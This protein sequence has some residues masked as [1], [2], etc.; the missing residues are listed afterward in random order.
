MILSSKAQLN[1]LDK[2]KLY[3][4]ASPYT[5]KG[6]TGHAKRKLEHDRYL[7][8]TH[9][10][11]TLMADYGLLLLTP[12]TASYGIVMHDPTS[13]LGG[14]WEQWAELD[15]KQITQSDGG[16]IVAMMDGWKESTGVT[17]EIKHAHS[18][19]RKVY[20]LH[21]TLIVGVTNAVH[22]I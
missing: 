13:S 6:L 11:A 15:T 9:I 16:I 18:I 5:A 2:S 14:N 17:A 1:R 3:Y 20:Y 21:P 8:I 10:G 19:G 22:K 4:L 7:D 12:I